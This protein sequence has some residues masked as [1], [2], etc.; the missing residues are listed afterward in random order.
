MS[1]QVPMP[2]T[3]QSLTYSFFTCPILFRTCSPRLQS[4]ADAQA[5]L[6]ELADVAAIPRGDAR[7]RQYEKFYPVRERRVGGPSLFFFLIFIFL[8]T[9]VAQ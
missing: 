3:P 2:P 5:V 9:G 8:S 4:L 7:R 1:L 6:K